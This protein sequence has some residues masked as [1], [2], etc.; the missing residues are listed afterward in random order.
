MSFWDKQMAFW[1][2]E[3]DYRGRSQQEVYDYQKEQANKY[4]SPELSERINKL[5][6]TWGKEE[7][8]EGLAES[9][10]RK[11]PSYRGGGGFTG[12]A[13]SDYYQDVPV[14]KSLLDLTNRESMASAREKG[15]MDFG[16]GEYG[17]NQA[18][19]GGPAD[20]SDTNQYNQR[21]LGSKF[22]RGVVQPIQNFLRND[23]FP[24]GYG[25]GD[26]SDTRLVEEVGKHSYGTGWGW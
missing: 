10:L 24:S 9:R 8:A 7:Y 5:Y 4:G 12:V 1:K 18:G 20:Y 26:S 17:S 14:S 25:M 15:M 13:Q 22:R 16:Y 23:L 3:Q 6:P 21:S 11:H 2:G 19:G